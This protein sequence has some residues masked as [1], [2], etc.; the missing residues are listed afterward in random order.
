MNFCYFI[1]FST[2]FCD[3]YDWH[4]N[5]HYLMSEGV[6]SEDLLSVL[7]YSDI[8]CSVGLASDVYVYIYI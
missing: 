7:G 8:Q 2:R 4:R 6:E 1:I 5:R 3:E